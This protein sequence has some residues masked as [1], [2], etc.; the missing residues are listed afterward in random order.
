LEAD[1]YWT[2]QHNNFANPDGYVSLAEELIQD[3]GDEVDY[4]VTAIGTGGSLCGTV[5]HLKRF[6][7]KLIA[8]GVEPEGSI[9]FGGRGH[10]YL[11]SGTGT[12]SNATVGLVVNYDIIDI[13][14]KVTDKHA[15]A[16]CRTLA[17]KFGLLVGGS[18]GGAIY[19]ALKIAHHAPIGTRVVTIACDSGMKYMDTIFDDDWLA[20]Q[21]LA[22]N[23]EEAEIK[24]LLN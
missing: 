18:A 10:K 6:N 24:V 12:P 13:G 4:F 7:P 15:F 3:L 14:K 9:I 5:A 19:E 20:R 22:L 1:T 23:E 16:T 17:L 21:G 11:Q 2:E 8:V